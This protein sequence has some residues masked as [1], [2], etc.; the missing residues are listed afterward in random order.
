MPLPGL[1]QLLM[2]SS[3]NP[4]I[5]SEEQLRLASFQYQL[6]SDAAPEPAR[7]AHYSTLQVL[8]SR[9]PMLL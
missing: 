2:F 8:F 3:L 5:S 1:T 6:G 7:F 9:T 4:S